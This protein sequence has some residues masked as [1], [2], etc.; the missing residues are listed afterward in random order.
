M[1]PSVGPTRPE[2]AL[3][4]RSA[5][6]PARWRRS[7]GGHDV[8]LVRFRSAADYASRMPGG[9]GRGLLGPRHAC[10][11]PTTWRN[12][13]VHRW[14]RRPSRQPVVGVGAVDAGGGDLV[15]LLGLTGHWVGQVDDV[16]DLGAA[17][18]GDLHGSHA[19]RRSAR[20]ACGEAMPGSR[21]ARSLDESA[22]QVTDR[23]GADHSAQARCTLRHGHPDVR[24]P[25]QPRRCRAPRTEAMLPLHVRGRPGVT[26]DRVVLRE[27]P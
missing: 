8:V 9:Q 3:C 25:G 16:E 24:F 7:S 19:V 23:L 13:S 5:A 17:E 26:D 6:A 14:L 1:G 15:E 12:M 18:A 27:A 22:A 10:P 11:R 20:R 2:A 21:V 4:D